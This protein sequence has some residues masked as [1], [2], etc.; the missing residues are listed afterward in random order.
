MNFN[1]VRL[2]EN[3]STHGAWLWVSKAE[4]TSK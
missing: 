2:D 3:I 4:D 1:T